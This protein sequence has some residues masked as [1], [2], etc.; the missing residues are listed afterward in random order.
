VI[1]C[2]NALAD[3]NRVLSNAG[4][5]L[6]HCSIA[7]ATDSK[8]SLTAIAIGKINPEN[9][10]AKLSAIRVSAAIT[11]CLNTRTRDNLNHPVNLL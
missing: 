9:Q 7:R 4:Q 5:S 10:R 8:K 11:V 2:R 1:A 6:S 3:T